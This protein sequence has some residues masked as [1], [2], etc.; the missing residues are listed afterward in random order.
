MRR[1][2]LSL[3][4]VRCIVQGNN[5]AS[6]CNQWRRSASN[7]RW[8]QA[9][10]ITPLPLDKTNHSLPTGWESLNSFKQLKF[11]FPIVCLWSVEVVRIA[12]IL[13][14]AEDQDTEEKVEQHSHECRPD[15]ASRLDWLDT[16]HKYREA[17][18]QNL[19]LWFHPEVSQGGRIVWG[20]V[21]FHGYCPLL[22]TWS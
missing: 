4:Q 10:H 17:V 5:L 2:H 18:G 1:I 19:S 3:L 16:A 20:D 11:Y 8:V 14:R 12:A 7:G 6:F 13:L 22:K 9:S 15:H 21:S